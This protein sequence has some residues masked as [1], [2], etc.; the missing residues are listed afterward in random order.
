MGIIFFNLGCGQ[1]SFKTQDS[2]PVGLGAQVNSS[3]PNASVLGQTI[4]SVSASS[5]GTTC[6][7]NGL[8]HIACFGYGGYDTLGIEVYSQSNPIL[9]D[10]NTIYKKISVGVTNT[11]GI[12]SAGIL[13][14]LGMAGALGNGSMSISLVPVV[15]DPGETYSDISVGQAYGC[16]ITTSGVLKCWGFN[17][18]GQLGSGVVL[19]DFVLSPQIVDPGVKYTQVSSRGNSTC[20]ITSLGALKCWG[21]LVKSASL[22]SYNSQIYS[23]VFYASEPTPLLIDPGVS[24]QYVNAGTDGTNC[25]ITNTGVLKCWGSNDSGQLGDGTRVAQLT[26]EE[27]D[28]GVKYTKVISAGWSATC[29]ITS[30]G[31]LKCWGASNSFYTADGAAP[32]AIVTTPTV[33]DAGVAYSDIAIGA[34]QGA[35]LVTTRGG[36]N[37]ICGVTTSGG[38]RCIGNNNLGQLGDGSFTNKYSFEN[39]SPFAHF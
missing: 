9:L 28:M 38:L 19:A 2:A 3:L 15:A 34:G 26:P 30:I 20:A 37:Y 18:N 14:C 5:F 32:A 11:C 39:L 21:Y 22:A 31:V 25:G 17:N 33:V 27:I 4:Q 24:Y 35:N 29:G 12:T 13:K 16:G 7:L 8:G 36:L 1:N 6:V 10:S 23:N